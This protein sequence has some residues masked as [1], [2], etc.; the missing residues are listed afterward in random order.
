MTAA[1]ALRGQVA[2]VVG[3]S[4][5]LGQAISITLAES[6]VRVF[7][8]ARHS[9]TL[10][11]LTRLPA[12]A[13]HGQIEAL[14]VDVIDNG[15][16]E[17]AVRHIVDAA[18][19][20]DILVNT[21]TVPTFGA[22]EDLGDAEWSQVLDTKLMGYVRTLRAVLPVM[23]SQQYGRIVNIT[24][25]GGRQPTAAHLPGS[26]ANAAVNLLTKGLADSYGARNIRVNAVAPG[27]IRSARLDRLLQASAQT[28]DRDA[29]G[30]IRTSSPIQRQGTPQDVADAVLYLVSPRSD[31]ITGIVLQVDGGGTVTV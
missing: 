29:P 13:E 2:W 8:S 28:N 23:A 1:A 26:C 15:S 21:T 22:F 18:E 19:R 17:S 24:G 14:P 5:A 11:P 4:G 3:A 16:V 9:R 6:G 25:R 30:Q 20:I 31:Y 7:A 10:A 27:P 12:S